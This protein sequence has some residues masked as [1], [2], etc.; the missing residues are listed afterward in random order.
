MKSN[1][2]LLLS[3]A[4]FFTVKAQSDVPVTHS[5][6]YGRN[7]LLVTAG[8]NIVGPGPG[9]QYEWSPG[10]N[11]KWSLVVP[12]YLSY[13]NVPPGHNGHFTTG[14]T[15]ATRTAVMAFFEPGIRFYPA[16]SNGVLRYS[17]E[18]NAVMGKGKGK[19][20][21][22]MHETNQLESRSVYGAVITNT[23]SIQPSRHIRIGLGLSLGYGTDDGVVN[24]SA[25]GNTFLAKLAIGV[26]YR[27]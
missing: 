6:V 8:C 1:L 25:G 21:I 9:L 26:G 20:H 10:A 19:G 13:A 15:G 18:L 2:L 4:G 3:V 11:H 24:Y 14:E 23:V 16:G 12:V 5:K 22:Y 27:W 17:A 7:S